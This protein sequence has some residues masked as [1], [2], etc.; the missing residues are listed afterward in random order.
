MTQ[1]NFRSE[2]KPFGSNSLGYI[3]IIASSVLLEENSAAI[4]TLMKFNFQAKLVVV[5]T[6]LI[7]LLLG[8]FP[9][10]FSLYHTA[11]ASNS[12]SHGSKSKSLVWRKR[13]SYRCWARSVLSNIN[14]EESPIR[15]SIQLS[16][17]PPPVDGRQRAMNVPPAPASAASFH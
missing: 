16:P 3:P 13:G 8:H 10:T 5:S 15:R 6:I 4:F 1:Q 12:R 2:L 14:T 9:A 11:A 17:P 7:L